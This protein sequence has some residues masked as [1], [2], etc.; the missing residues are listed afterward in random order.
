MYKRFLEFLEN[1]YSIPFYR[2]VSLDVTSAFVCIQIGLNKGKFC[3]FN[4]HFAMYDCFAMRY[5][6]RKLFFQWVSRSRYP[7]VD[8]TK[9][10]QAF[11]FR[12]IF[13]QTSKRPSHRPPKCIC[14]HQNNLTSLLGR[15]L[16]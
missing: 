3:L 8:A 1:I 15:C 6:G 10:L 14:V 11:Y 9:N 12:K 16:I 4:G 7:K 13:V 2:A 5:N